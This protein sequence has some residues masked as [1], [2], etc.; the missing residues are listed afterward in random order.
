MQGQLTEVEHTIDVSADA[1]EVY[2]TLADV[3]QWPRTFPPTIHAEQVEVDDSLERIRIWARAGDGVK[4]W[5]SIRD[6]DPAGRRI[7]FRQERSQSPVASMA[8]TWIV[9]P[10]AEGSTVR[11]L[12][13]YAAEQPSDQA[14][15]D[16]VVDENSRAEL[17]SLKE[18]LEAGAEAQGLATVSFEDTVEMD[19]D[20]SEAFAFID[21]AERWQERLP[22]VTRV[23]FAE[24]GHGVQDLEMDTRSP[25]GSAHTT[26][27]YR[28][29][30]DSG[31]IVYKQVTLPALMAV[32][33]GRWSFRAQ[34]DGVAVTSQHTVV[35][36]QDQ[37]A[38]VLGPDATLAD[39]TAAVR[40]ALSAN[41]LATLG[42]AKQSLEQAQVAEAS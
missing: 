19:G 14:W 31:D 37:I 25:D 21:R 11:L 15:L 42:L 4:A 35:V 22:H 28:V 18:S 13:A 7:E 40:K 27:S 36:R 24:L 3:S 32:H 1:D 38:S 8:G 26:R 23:R 33:T 30:L 5:A 41:S 10:T 12:H 6:L 17:A 9:E 39:A 29:V 16:R 34:G 20:P 2:A